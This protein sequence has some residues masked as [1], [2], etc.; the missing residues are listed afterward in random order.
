[1]QRTIIAMAGKMGSG[2]DTAGDF[3]KA[4]GYRQIA[5]ADNLKLMSMKIFGLSHS[6]CY[7]Q[8]EKIKSFDEYKEITR[9]KLLEIKNYAFKENG[10]SLNQDME[11]KLWKLVHPYDMGEEV[12]VVIK[13]PRELLQYLGTEVLRNCIDEDYHAKV[14]KHYIDKYKWDKVVITDCRFPNEKRLVNEWGGKT[15][16]IDRPDTTHTGIA[17]HAS[18]TSLGDESTYDYVIKND[19]SL[20]EFKKNVLK[21]EKEIIN[22]RATSDSK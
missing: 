17:N 1:M 11:A 6:Q 5:F 9:T 18:E 13:S 19:K 16:L 10:F 22:E 12:P 8:D 7:D 3:L 2:K 20:E 15:I 4:E 14:V 21:V